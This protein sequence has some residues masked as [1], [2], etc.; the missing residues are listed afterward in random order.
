VTGGVTPVS[1]SDVAL[2]EAGTNGY[3]T[4]ATQLGST[5]TSAADGSFAVALASCPSAS[6]QIYLT[7]K[8]GNAGGGINDSLMMMAALGPCGSINFSTPVIIN[9]VTTAGSVYAL[10]QFLNT[11]S[12]GKVG[13]PATNAAG[14]AD[15]FGNAANLMSVA[16][17][18][19]LSTTPGGAG[20]A[21]QDNLNSIANAL[22]AC[23]Q[24]SGSASANCKELFAC[25]LPGAVF[26]S[27]ACTGGTGSLA[28]TLT[29]ALSIARNPAGVSV[30]GVNDVATKAALFSPALASAPNDWSMPLNFAPTG[31]N[32]NEPLG[33]AID[34]SGHVWITNSNGNTV[35]ALNNDGTLF[36]NFDDT[37]TSGANFNTPVGVAI[38][39]SGRVWVTNDG[40]GPGGLGTVTA[41]NSDGSFDLN[42]SSDF[43]GPEGVAID[44]SGHVWVANAAGGA[45]PGFTGYVTALFGDGSLD[46]NFFPAGSDFEGP[47][48]VAIA[49]TGVVWVTNLDGNTLTALHNNGTLVGNFHSTLASLS[50]PS[51]IAIDSSGDLWV[52]NEGGDALTEVSI[53]GFIFHNFALT[54]SFNGSFGVAIDSSGHVWV[55]NVI[56][57]NVTALNNDGT[58]SGNFGPFNGP[59]GV[60]IDSSGNLWVANEGGGPDGVGVATELVGVAAPVLTPMVAC[61]KQTTP[62][63]V[64][65]P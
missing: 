19:A 17:G 31:S 25:A 38:D 26:N 21:P 64:C 33:L 56:G 28:D 52:A 39:G 65:L 63:T 8:G 46:G 7:A 16:S 42:N 54:G 61:L 22:G 37:N 3:G 30:A 49:S 40:G 9:E 41:L 1:G 36:G 45:A 6:T 29:A 58:L 47:V 13:A 18:S 34:S 44:G 57:N 27:G 35:T 14:L 32:F 4:G 2:W 50:G 24:T 48:N 60:A 53:A 12:S 15:A 20:T 55:T 10:S 59:F 23:V 43:D 62:A 5:A 11:T 51:G